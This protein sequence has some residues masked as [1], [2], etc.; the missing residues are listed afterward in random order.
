MNK[1]RATI[2]SKLHISG[3]LE[4]LIINCS[5]LIVFSSCT[6]TETQYWSPGLKRSEIT[7]S[8]GKMNGKAIWWYQNGAIQQ[9]CY[10]K[11]NK[12]NGLSVRL[13]GNSRRQ[14]EE[15]Y[16]DD[17]LDGKSVSYDKDGNRINEIHYTM[18]EKDGVYI[19]WHY[20]GQ[21]RV[22]G[23]YN[24]GKFDKEWEY[25]NI[26]GLKIGDGKFNNGTGILNTYSDKTGKLIR[27]SS[28][29]N[30]L[31]NGPEKIWDEKGNLIS[32]KIYKDD[33]IDN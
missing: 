7:Y 21:M 11:N 16:K 32:E 3:F 24:K 2:L 1:L 26:D 19:E 27:Q 14:S 4:L 31:K 10:Y 20:N 22:K 12:L 6:H 30:N 13:Y 33:K 9:I 8:F 23:F 5:L 18:G 28:Y 25:W 17:K 29:I 15:Y